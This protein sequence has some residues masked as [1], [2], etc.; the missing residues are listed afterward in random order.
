MC[1]PYGA[2]TFIGDDPALTGWANEFRPCG[3]RV[4]VDGRAGLATIHTQLA[5]AALLFQFA[6]EVASLKRPSHQD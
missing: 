4:S 1:R 2:C 6:Q 3:T 5:V